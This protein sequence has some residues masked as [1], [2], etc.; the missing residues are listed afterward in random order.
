MQNSL[1]FLV[2]APRSGTTL[3]ARIL[4]A[5][6]EV[7]SRS[8]PHLIT[9]LAHLGYFGSV[10]KAP[11]DPFNVQQA[12][13]ELVSDL[14]G[15]EEDYLTALRAYTDTLYGS[16]LEQTPDKKYFLDKTPAIALVLPFLTKLYPQAGYVVLIR[17][18]LAILSSYVNSFF[19]GDYQVALEHNP[20]LQRYVPA[21][22]R[23]LREKPVPFVPIRYED[24]VADPEAGFHKICDHLGISF[25]SSAINY[26]EQSDEFQGLGDP[27]GVGQHDRPV[28]SSIKRWAVEIATN[29]QSLEQVMS[30][31]DQLEDEDLET[32]GYPRAQIL[33]DLNEAAAS[34]TKP[35]KR[36]RPLRYT[37]ERKLLIGLR[38]N[39]HKNVLGRLLKKL[40]F[41]LDVI[42]RD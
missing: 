13:Q 24:F 15:G 39:I 6:S 5:H 20:I 4:G 27:I 11:Y 10:Q 33:D 30:V 12:I 1:I 25:E 40:Q 22:A 36:S 19:D 21:L 3:L 34:G 32:L 38:R 9:P 42:L 26:Q 14:P 7:A 2:G 35:A 41:A 37:M 29:P 17:H 18:P 31:L 16:I 23:M 28:T 8:E